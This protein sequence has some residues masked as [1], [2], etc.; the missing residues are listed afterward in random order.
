MSVEIIKPRIRGFICTNA[1]PVGCRQNVQDQVNYIKS[2]TATKQ[3]GLNALVWS[4]RLRDTGSPRALH[5]P[6]HTA[7]NRWG[8]SMNA[9]PPENG[10]LPRVIITLPAFHQLAAQDGFSA[11][12]INGDAFSDEVK[13]ETVDRIKGGMGK[14]DTLVYSIAAPPSNPSAHRGGA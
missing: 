4:V 7:Q 13:Q 9:Q 1:H 3:T 5:S 14:I 8:S 11:E 6:G 10:L 12:S 2:T